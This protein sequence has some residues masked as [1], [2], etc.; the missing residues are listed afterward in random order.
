MKLTIL[1]SSAILF[2]TALTPIS[3]Y[4]DDSNL[5]CNRSAN[6]CDTRPGGGSNKISINGL[7]VDVGS[8]D[9]GNR[10]NKRDGDRNNRNRTTDA[11]DKA[12]HDNAASADHPDADD[13][14]NTDA[15]NDVA[16]NTPDA[17]T[18]NTPDAG[19]D[20]NDTGNNDADTNNTDT[21]NNDAGTDNNDT[22]ASNNTPPQSNSNDIKGFDP[23][24]GLYGPGT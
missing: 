8:M 6:G 24:G 18:D 22:G 5:S 20:N 9:R 23:F 1:L 21:G 4:A 12:G 10:N 7:V 3:A 16:D 19:T 11:N 17:G 14:D 2:A 15:D 13:T